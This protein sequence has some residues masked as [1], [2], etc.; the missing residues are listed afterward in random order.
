MLIVTGIALMAVVAC[1]Y[2]PALERT[3]LPLPETPTPTAADIEIDNLNTA[4][5]VAAFMREEVGRLEDHRQ[6]LIREIHD[7]ELHKAG[8]E[9]QAERVGVPQ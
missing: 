8:L 4:I 2:S 9:A 5:Q 1:G 6:L 3:P 7:L